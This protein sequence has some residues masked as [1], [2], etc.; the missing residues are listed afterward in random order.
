MQKQPKRIPYKER[1]KKA[2]EI[3][4]TGVG[5]DP[6]AK[7]LNCSRTQAYKILQEHGSQAEFV[8]VPVPSRREIAAAVRDINKAWTSND[9]KVRWVGQWARTD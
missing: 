4:K 5:I 9:R 7:V 8:R 1:I 2:L 6:V 3:H